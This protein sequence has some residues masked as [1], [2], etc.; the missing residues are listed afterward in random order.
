MNWGLEPIVICPTKPEGG[1][2]VPEV[3]RRARSWNRWKR[4]R[5]GRVKQARA[6]IPIKGKVAGACD[7]CAG[8]FDVKEEVRDAGIPFLSEFEGHPSLRKRV[9][10]GYQIVTF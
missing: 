5:I 4:I 1:T 10:E 3:G 8:A 6:T 2:R 9:A 7:F